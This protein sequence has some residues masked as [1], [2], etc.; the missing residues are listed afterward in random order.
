MVLDNTSITMSA[1]S[2]QIC[3]EGSPAS[4]ENR[5][6]FRPDPHL[7]EF[8]EFAPEFFPDRALDQRKKHGALPL[9]FF[10]I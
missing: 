9:K 6:P 7:G 10:Q 3:A 5:L 4:M 1:E 2:F 8:L